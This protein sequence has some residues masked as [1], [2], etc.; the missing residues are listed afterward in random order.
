MAS[1]TKAVDQL[2]ARANKAQVRP[3]TDKEIDLFAHGIRP[4]F[5]KVTYRV[6]PSYRHV[7]RTVGAMSYEVR[8]T[9]EDAGFG[10]RLLGPKDV[11]SDT[12]ELV[13]VPKNVKWADPKGNECVITTNHLVAF[14]AWPADE[15]EAR[16]CFDLDDSKSD[17]E[18]AVYLHHQDEPLAKNLKTGAWVDAKASKPKYPNFT[19]W[20]AAAV[21]AFEKKARRSR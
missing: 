18:L 16:W 9:Y 13:H 12:R 10:F 11:I 4:H 6:P 15:S 1:S 19:A 7:L 21:S 2:I 5:G 14:A 17:G 3:L 8:D 20:L